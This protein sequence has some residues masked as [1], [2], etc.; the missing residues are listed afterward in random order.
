M[1][2]KYLCFV[3]NEV[4]PDRFIF[5]NISH[6]KGSFKLKDNNASLS[7][8]RTREIFSEKFVQIGLEKGVFGTHSLRAGGASLAAQQNIPDRLF[9]AHGRWRSERA[10][11][12]Y[13]KDSLDNR[14]R[15]TRDPVELEVPI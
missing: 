15:V 6:E 13:I 9:K 4:V 5:R 12:G 2:Q 14:L 3:K 11:D 7:Y 10:K 1:V 8:S